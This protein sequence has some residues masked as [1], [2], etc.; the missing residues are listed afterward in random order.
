M[1]PNEH[2]ALKVLKNWQTVPGGCHLVPEYVE[3]RTLFCDER[4]GVEQGKLEMWIDMFPKDSAM[5]T[6]VVDITPRQPKRFTT[7]ENFS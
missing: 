4:P 1:I 7:I 6:N 3:T 5:P 2:L